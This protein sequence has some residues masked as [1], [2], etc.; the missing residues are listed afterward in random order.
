VSRGRFG[1]RRQGRYGPTQV[2]LASGEAM[3]P[4]TSSGP[5]VLT[6][7]RATGHGSS[8][9]SVRERSRSKAPRPGGEHRHAIDL[10]RRCPGTRARSRRATMRRTQLQRPRHRSGEHHQT[11]DLARTRGRSTCLDLTEPSP[12]DQSQRPRQRS[13]RP[14]RLSQLRRAASPEW[15]GPRACRYLSFRT[16]QAL[17]FAFAEAAVLALRLRP[18]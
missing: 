9:T 2:H 15:R 3:G 4:R 5:T 7:K 18:W 16:A 13:A 10:A 1:V 14:D 12:A 11:V 17:A 6:R 8:P